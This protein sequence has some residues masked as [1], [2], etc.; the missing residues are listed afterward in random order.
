LHCAGAGYADGKHFFMGPGGQAMTNFVEQIGQMGGFRGAMN[1]ELSRNPLLLAGYQKTTFVDL[2]Y[3]QKNYLKEETWAHKTL[4]EKYIP[5]A[6][7]RDPT[8][9]I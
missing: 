6:R 8:K 1:V 7:G 9:D 4:V 2:Q 3:L 5:L